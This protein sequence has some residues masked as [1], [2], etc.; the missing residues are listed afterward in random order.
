MVKNNIQYFVVR[1]LIILIVL[2]LVMAIYHGARFFLLV[3]AGGL[4]AILWRGVAHWIAE[5]T[6]M[7][8]KWLLP[9]VIILNIG[10]IVAFFWL[11]SPNIS[12]QM[13]R[14]VNEIP[15]ALGRIEEWLQRSQFG[16]NLI[17]SFE[18]SKVTGEQVSRAF[19]I[20]GGTMNLI[21]DA[22]LILVFALFL[23]FGPQLYRRGI[24]HMVPKKYQSTADHLLLEQKEVLFR[25]FIGK[26]IDMSSI[27]IMTIIGLWILDM[28]MIFTFALIAFFFSFVPN[29]GPILSAIPPMAIAL[30]DSPQ[31]ML[32]V[33]LLYLGI[34]LIESYFITPNVQKR[35]SY[36]PP[37]ILLLVQFLFAKFLGVLGLFLSTP[38][39][40]LIMV[41]V[42]KLYVRNYLG[43]YHD[44]ENNSK[45]AG[46][47]SRD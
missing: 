22:L 18:D 19:D 30:L 31:K 44:E 11:A 4:I 34:Q 6:G 39:L 12:E 5:K 20:V 46:L 26:I 3:L 10:L 29:I 37:V 28:P 33:G 47:P 41:T 17:Q 9:V 32:Y 16:R 38:L 23:A 25:W 36:V 1:I 2:A 35:A 24:L 13:N 27:F 7:K 14:L 8:F 40:V 42:N 43:N 15:Q 21:I 45:T